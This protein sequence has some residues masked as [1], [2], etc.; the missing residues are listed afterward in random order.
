MT[1]WIYTILSVIIVSLISLIGVFTFAIS[2]EKLKKVLIYLVSFAAGT[3][4]GDAFI[5]LIP[6]AF[7]EI[8][9]TVFLSLSILA[10]ILAFFV[11][12]KFLHWRHCHEVACEDHPH[13]FSCVL[14]VG[15]VLHNFID[16]LIIAASYLVSIPVGI[17][18]TLAVIFHEIPQEIGDFGSL[19]YAGF[20]KTKALFFNFLTALTAVLGA[21]IVLALNIS[22]GSITKF[23]VPFAAGG[24]IYIASSDLIPELHKDTD[25]KKSFWQ[26][27]A[28]VLGIG[29]MLLLITLE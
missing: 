23:L 20:K 27:V 29:L 6:E 21:I 8:E 26:L 7:S 14:L 2:A 18:T 19:L 3:L 12:E 16:G 22:D 9:N 17:A 4:L 28:F 5:H 10:G 1:I 15:D 13:P 11:M 25:P 24:F